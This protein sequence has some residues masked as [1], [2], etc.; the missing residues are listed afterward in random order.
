MTGHESPEKSYDLERL[1]FFTDG[2]FAIVITLLVI[3]LKPPPGWD[4]T[5]AGLVREEWR[6]LAAYAISFFATGM[7]WNSHRLVFGV[8][9]RFHP[10]LVG[11]NLLFLGLVVLVPFAATLIFQTGPRGEPF[12]IYLGLFAAIGV[13]QTMLW[14]FAAFAVDVVDPRVAR[15]ARVTM[16]LT[17]LAVPVMLA[18][19]GLLA[20]RGGGSLIA[21]ILVPTALIVRRARSR[22]IKRDLSVTNSIEDLR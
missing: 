11:F 2:V 15:P 18:G 19:A 4:A 16:L 12:L 13:A 7:F 22:A 9:V 5:F 3:E 14:A 10:G 8:I 21:I 6:S 20:S 17:M 1:V